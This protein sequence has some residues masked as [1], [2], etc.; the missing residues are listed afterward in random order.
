MFREFFCGAAAHVAWVGLVL[1]IVNSVFVAHIKVTLNTFYAEFFDLMQLSGTLLVDAPGGEHGSGNDVAALFWRATLRRD[2]ASKLQE[3][4]I[5]VAP[6]V[7]LSPIAK[8]VRSHW[9]LSWRVALM[10]SYLRHWDVD[11]PPLEG[12]SQ[13]LHEDSQRFASALQG[14]L[15]SAL[16]ALFSLVLFLPILLE[17]STR[18]APP[19][20]LGSLRGGWLVVAA[21]GAA[22][23]GLGGAALVGMRLVTLEVNNQ[24]VE[25]ALRKDLVLLETSPVSLL[26]RR[27]CGAPSE[28]APV[29]AHFRA[30]VAR[31]RANYS[32]LFRHFSGLNLWLATF[33]QTMAIFPYVVTAH[34]LFDDDPARRITLGVLVQVSNSFEKVFQSMSVISE[35]WGAINEFRSVL[36]RLREFESQLHAAT[37]AASARGR[38]RL[39][40]PPPAD[41]TP[42]GTPPRHPSG[43][44]PEEPEEGECEL[45]VRAHGADCYDM[46]V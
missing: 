32:A 18:C 12:A 31:L 42:P 20:A 11:A 37:A 29:V 41:A 35:N 10:T 46:R 15:I 14:C 21:V 28:D 17:L 44:E 1:V 8:W 40:P 2:V 25:A 33:D 39:L 34:L 45:C 7:L 16:D 4:A 5:I 9:A 6:L 3:F 27:E 36:R 13:R 26:G 23:L 24:R 38:T 43:E 30:P 22:L 19:V